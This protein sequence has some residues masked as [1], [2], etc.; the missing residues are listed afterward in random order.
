MKKIFNFFLFVLAFQME[1]RV[2][3]SGDV[4]Q[5]PNACLKAQEVCAIQVVGPVFHFHQGEKKLHAGKGSALV[6]L[7]ESQWRFVKGSLWVE[8]GSS[9][10]VESVYGSFKASRGQYWVVDQS[11][12]IIIR[13]MNADVVITLRDGHRLELPEGFEVWVG[14]L[15]SKGVSEFGMIRPVEMREHL[16]MWNALYRGSKDNFV[17]EVVQLRENWGD[18]TE[19]SSEL[20][21]TLAKRELAS[22]AESEKTAARKK[23]RAIEE[24]REVKALLYKKVFER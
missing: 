20:Y 12:R 18:L 15:N 1:V 8:E 14:G 16:P 24:R 19:K 3:A 5:Q 10:G 9:L 11:D 6:R 22:V 13:N 4:L 23:A 17:K 7:S 2:R 21:E